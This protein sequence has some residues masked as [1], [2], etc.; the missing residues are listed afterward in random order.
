M[1][2]IIHTTANYF[3]HFNQTL[4]TGNQPQIVDLKRDFNRYSFLKHHP[5]KQNAI[6]QVFEKAIL[7]HGQAVSC[8]S[9]LQ[10][11]EFQ[12]KD[13]RL[14]ENMGFCQLSNH[15]ETGLVLEHPDF[16]EWLIKKNYGYRQVEN[17]LKRIT[18]SVSATDFPWW[19]LPSRLREHSKNSQIGIRVPNDVINPLRVVILE[20]GQ[21]CINDLGLDKVRA[22]KEYLYELP[23]LAQDEVEKPW[24]E[25][26]VVISKKEKIV[27]ETTNL[28]RFVGMAYHCPSKLIRLA[29]QI[30]YF[31]KYTLVTDTH[32]NN[33]RFLDDD[34]DT[35]LFMDGEPVGGLADVSEPRMA[36]AVQEY[37]PGF[38]A[39]LGLKK[40]II[41][42]RENMEDEGIP[43][44]DIQE[45]QALFNQ[46]VD[47]IK[48]EI[49]RERRW[50]WLKA[51]VDD[52]LINFNSALYAIV[53]SIRVIYQHCRLF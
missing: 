34:T 20:R 17:Q 23:M 12:E 46:A 15:E 14:L 52:Y 37:D 27:S 2:E 30:A 38:F 31:I 29:K 1:F 16:P 35:V 49:I 40:L 8:N 22:A 19:M 3:K 39:L 48:D 33:I 51:I 50:V 13:V 11:V 10:A 41:S 9:L 4:E 21:Q 32:L 5:G 6:Q 25:R 47:P 7:N 28:Y 44:K 43:E 53:S 24:Y 42:I 45:V 26:I 18:K 36:S